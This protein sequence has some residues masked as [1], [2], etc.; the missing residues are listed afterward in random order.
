[1]RCPKLTFVDNAEKYKIREFK[2]SI[3]S[4]NFCN[5]DY[6]LKLNKLFYNKIFG[7]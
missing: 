1:M 5:A 3:A 2:I 4:R 6:I 7:I